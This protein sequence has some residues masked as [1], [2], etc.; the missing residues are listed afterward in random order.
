V[1][2]EQTLLD[3]LTLVDDV[4]RYVARRHR[5][6]ADEADELASVV[7]LKLVENDYDVLRKFENR[8]SLRTY[9]T[10]VIQRCFLDGRIARWGK[11]RPSAQARRLGPVAMRLDQLL[12][13]D[14]VPLEEA[15]E[16]LLT[17]RAVTASK[18]ELFAMALQL[19]D[20]MPRRFVGEEQL[21][22]VAARGD[23]EDAVIGALDRA[24]DAD[25]IEVALAAALRQL[26]DQ[27]RLILKMRFEN[28]FQIAH[29]ARLLAIEQKPLYRRLEQIMKVLRRELEARGVSREQMLLIMDQL[30]AHAE[31]PVSSDPS[32]K[33]PERPSLS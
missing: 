7:R 14:G 8:C 5:L 13:R 21:E 28:D 27:D 20:R 19:P 24:R 15:V 6:S 11:W 18:E 10:A 23:G 16:R 30:A 29:I 4:V 12:T 32:G 3:N 26:G 22:T 33:R 9:L 1:N 2:C 17:D 25:R 31:R